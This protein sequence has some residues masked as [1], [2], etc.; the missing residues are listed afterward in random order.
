MS[1]IVKTV[2]LNSNGEAVT[3]PYVDRDVQ[4]TKRMRIPLYVAGKLKSDEELAALGLTVKRYTQA[5]LDAEECA[6]LYAANPDLAR[7]VGE[8]KGY[9]DQ[10]GITDYSVNTDMIEEAIAIS[11]TIEDKEQYVLR[12]KT[13]FDNVVL[14]LQAVNADYT[15][16]NA[17]EKMPVMIANLPSSAEATEGMPA[18]AE[19]EELATAEPSEAGSDKSEP[20]V[21][22]EQSVEGAE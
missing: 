16:F 6:G 8:Y 18:E 9:L 7:R 2:I 19:S 10:I 20:S 21:Q 1:E 11:T 15:S 22:S 3:T 14:N 4:I 12:I 17:W 5:E 13:A